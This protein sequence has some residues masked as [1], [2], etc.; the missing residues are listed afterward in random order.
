MK[1]TLITTNKVQFTFFLISIKGFFFKS[2]IANHNYIN[3]FINKSHTDRPT[4]KVRVRKSLYPFSHH[5]VLSFTETPEEEK[6][7]TDTV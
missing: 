1:R 3:N 2:A 7:H 6:S 5:R 4:F